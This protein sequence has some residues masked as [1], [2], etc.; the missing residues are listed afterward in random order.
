MITDESKANL[1]IG[2]SSINTNRVN[3]PVKTS[4]FANINKVSFN[5]E[6]FSNILLANKECESAI[7]EI[8][9]E[10]LAKLSFKVDDFTTQYWLVA[11]SEVD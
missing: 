5:A 7:L 8:S 9:S 3:I 10:G 4:R 6:H 11:T 1:I 2:Y